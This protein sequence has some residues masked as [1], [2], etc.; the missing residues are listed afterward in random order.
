[1]IGELI[2]NY[3][4][5]GILAILVGAMVWYLKYQTKRQATREDKHD[6]ERI[7]KEKKRDEERK[8]ETL[9]IR[10]LLTN[11]VKELH[12]DSLKNADLNKQSLVLQKDMIKQFK[13]HNGHSKKAWDKT[14]KSL[15]GVCE[16]LNN[17]EAE[18]K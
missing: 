1:M 9:F 5:P 2:S 3:A 8:E 14:I 15:S 18:G 7:E 10:G 12:K 4:E 13:D 11:D 17:I 16:K 6:V